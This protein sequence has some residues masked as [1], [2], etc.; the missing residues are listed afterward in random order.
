MRYQ[1]QLAKM[2][3]ELGRLADPDVTVDVATDAAIGL[4]ARA[5]EL[6]IWIAQQCD[7][8]AQTTAD[9]CSTCPKL[10]NIKPRR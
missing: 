2:V 10:S 5:K 6:D 4:R 1:E 9:N 7:L 3:H 8:C